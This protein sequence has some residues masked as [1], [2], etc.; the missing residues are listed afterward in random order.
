MTCLLYGADGDSGRTRNNEVAIFD[1]W[2]N[3]IQHK[4]NDVWFDGQEKN[5]TF[6]YGFFVAGGEIDTKF[7][8]KYTHHKVT[9]SKDSERHTHNSL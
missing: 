7:L 6:A 9:L 5:I 3:F 4:R 8:Q 1:V 2:A